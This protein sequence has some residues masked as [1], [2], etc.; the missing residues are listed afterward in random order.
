MTAFLDELARAMAKPLPRRR[1]LRLFGG[2]IVALALPA[3]RA[4]AAPATHDCPAQGLVL[5]QCPA[6]NGL[7]FKLCCWSKEACTCDIPRQ[8]TCCQYGKIWN[9]AKCVCK[10]QCG[11]DKCCA[12]DE[13]CANVRTQLL[14][15]EGREGVREPV[16]LP[17]ERRVRQRPCPRDHLAEHLCEA[18]PAKSGVVRQRQVLSPEVEVQE[19]EH[20]AL[21]ALR[22]QRGRVREEVLRQETTR[23]CGKAGCCPKTR[24]CCVNGDKQV[25]CPAGTKC[26]IPILP[27]DIGVKPGTDAICCPSARLNNQPKVCCP[28]GQV[29]LNTPGFRTPPPGI[30]PY[31]CPPGQVCGSGS[32]KFCANLQSDSQNCGQC[33]NVCVSGICSGG[34]CALP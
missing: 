33:G 1:A 15:Q 19:P 13:F 31:C 16:L 21:Q 32:G 12:S 6:A 18:L 34:I 11:G 4:G 29:A 20:R 22:A 5:C 3:A 30:S 9:G 2:A 24:S 23:C 27:G 25:C 8:A 14:L 7:F 10:E 26:A 17:E 28:A